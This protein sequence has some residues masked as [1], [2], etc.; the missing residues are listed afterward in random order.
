MKNQIVWVDIP[1]NDLDRAISFYSQVLEGKVTKENGH[2][3][4]IFGLLPHEEGNVSACL[5]TTSDNTPSQNGPLVYLNAEGRL[6]KAMKLVPSLGGT[7]LQE[8]QPIGKF[9]FRVVIL[10][11]EGNRIAL[12]SFTQ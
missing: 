12:H 4:V 1:V 3:G 7:I 6:T 8:I 10:D 5:F 11:S 9:G 2:A